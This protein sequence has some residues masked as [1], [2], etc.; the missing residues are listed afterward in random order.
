MNNE[1][2]GDD[3]LI[4]IT[5]SGPQFIDPKKSYFLFDKQNKNTEKSPRRDLMN[6]NASSSDKKSTNISIIIPTFKLDE[7]KL[8]SITEKIKQKIT[9]NIR[10]REGFESLLQ[11]PDIK[12]FINK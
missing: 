1:L 6:S 8:D 5:K 7:D 11:D 3:Y 2:Q 9:E 12:K 10:N 4:E